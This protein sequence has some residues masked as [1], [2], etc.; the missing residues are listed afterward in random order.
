MPLVVGVD[1]SESGLRAV[2]WAADDADLHDVPLLV[3][4]GTLWER[5]EGAALARELGRPSTEMTADD[6]LKATARRVRRRHPHLVVTTETVPDEA[7]HALVC[8]GRNASM[9]IVGSRGRSGGAGRCADR[10]SAS[11][12]PR[13]GVTP[14]DVSADS[15]VA[16]G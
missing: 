14:P 15:A 2:D 10:R 6:I 8:A 11:A 5:Y 7:E 1:G 9:I 13:A 4:F 16:A 3:V 12:W